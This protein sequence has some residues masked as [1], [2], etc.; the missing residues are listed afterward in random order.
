[1]AEPGRRIAVLFHANEHRPNLPTYLISHLAEFWREDGH[2]VRFVF[3]TEERVAADVLF[4]HVNLSVV[5]KRYAAYATT[6]PAAVNGAALDIRKSV[7]S[8][9]LVR[10]GDGWD[11]PVILKSNLNFNGS[12]ERIL[13]QS[14]LQR[15]SRLW[16]AATQRIAAVHDRR[17]TGYRVLER[18]ADV[19]AG[20]FAREDVVVERF[21]PEVE[22][23]LYHM[24]MYQ[25][26]GDRWTCQRL[27]SNDQ[28]IKAGNSVSAAEV[29]PHPELGEWRKELRLDFGKLD[30]VVHDGRPVL[31]D[32]NKTT[33]ASRHMP[34]DQ[35]AVLRRRLAEGLYSYFV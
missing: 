32:A 11:G 28:V 26:L 7:V 27:A 17:W 9:Q 5:P 34:P 3:G 25:F 2:E 4:V 6:F 33:G 24:R 31:L 30:Y 21:L 12:P 23:G 18:A 35:L 15:R 20:L 22:D 19:P 29:E 10:P 8:R 16:R 13:A 14:R 1:M